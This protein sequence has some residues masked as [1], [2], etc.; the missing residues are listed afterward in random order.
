MADRLAVVDHGRVVQVGPPLEVYFR[1]ANEFVARFM[2][3][4]PMN[5]FDCEIV[6]HEDRP[7]ISLAG[8][9]LAM[10]CDAGRD[11][12]CRCATGACVLASGPTDIAIV[13]DAGETSAACRIRGRGLGSRAVRAHIGRHVARRRDRFQA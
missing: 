6:S 12:R 4:P 7:A 13:C 9:K 11:P 5:I 1:P 2:G 8:Q 10:I 3:D